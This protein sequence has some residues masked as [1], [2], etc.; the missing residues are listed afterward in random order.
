VETNAGY[1][2]PN[3]FVITVKRRDSAE[4]PVRFVLARDGV[5]R[6]KLSAV[7]LP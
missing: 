6:W 3:H 7:D 4:G 5:L 2:G 1:D